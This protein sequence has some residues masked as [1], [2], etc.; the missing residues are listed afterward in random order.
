MVDIVLL[1]LNVFASSIVI[2][3]L[4]DHQKSKLLPSISPLVIED[5]INDSGI[6]FIVPLSTVV[7]DPFNKD[8]LLKDI[9]KVYL[10]DNTD[11]IFP[12]IFSLLAV[13]FNVLFF[14][15][16]ILSEML[17]F[18]V[19]LSFY[20]KPFASKKIRIGYHFIQTLVSYFFNN[21]FLRK[22]W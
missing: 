16:N 1:V 14:A 12:A 17:I 8:I 15:S 22:S 3:W 7:F 6:L 20:I 2:L 18:L 21:L 11:F 4:L 10:V 19:Y 13:T 9:E 5:I